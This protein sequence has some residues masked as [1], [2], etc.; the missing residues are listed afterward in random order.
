[1]S[2]SWE[3]TQI[4]DYESKCWTETED[5]KALN[6]VTSALIW[7]CVSVDMKEITSNN[8]EEFYTRYVMLSKARGERG[9]LTMEDVKAHVGLWT[10]VNTRTQ[11]QFNK[12]V[13]AALRERV[14]RD[15]RREEK[16]TEGGEQ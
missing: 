14:E 15:V 13:G 4:E 16:G 3:L 6:P 11:A 9:R 2:L 1:M 5:G 8:A 10:N 7:A 12:K